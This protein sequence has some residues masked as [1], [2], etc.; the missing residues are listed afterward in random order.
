MT[1]EVQSMNMLY[2][3]V[4]DIT[5]KLN[6]DFIKFL[7]LCYLIIRNTFCMLNREKHG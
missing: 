2:A 5:I 1:F 6:P 3:F 4:F 7:Q